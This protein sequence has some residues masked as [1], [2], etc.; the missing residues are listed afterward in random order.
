MASQEKLLESILELGNPSERRTRPELHARA[1]QVALAL[2]DA[3]AAA[4][5][6]TPN[7]KRGERLVL[8]A[9]SDV[10]A[11]IP[12]A[13]EGSI[14]TL[15]FTQSSEPVALPDLS[16]DAR[17]AA[18]DACPGVE[19]GP[20]LFTPLLQR[21]P[22]PAYLAVYR[23]RGRARFTMNDARS[24]LLLGAWL[25][26]ALENLR[27]A[28]GTEKL[29]VTDDLT[30]VY[31]QRFLRSALRREIQ[32]AGRF[33]QEL[34]LVVIDVDHFK[35][36]TETQGELKSSLL[37]KEL[38]SVLAQ[39][40]RA[41]DVLGRS[42]DDEFLLILPQ[43]GR[44]GA[45]EVAERVRAVVEQHAFTTAPAGTITVS[46]GVAAFPQAGTDIKRLTMAAERA[47]QRAKELGRNRV[48]QPPRKAA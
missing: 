17:I 37:L 42:G 7:G 35:I 41:F 3:D 23:R 21:D 29:A 19:A 27:L 18:G 30:E 16:E 26:T 47:L 46:L 13:G 33:K 31:N 4:L 8:H 36:C 22:L 11:R 38:S 12:L 25:S 45:L 34:A 20:A 10:P 39:E 2:T 28:T 32:R 5:V 9:G 1:L 14:V 40:V 6:L 48:A 24:M 44:D 15:G 43:T